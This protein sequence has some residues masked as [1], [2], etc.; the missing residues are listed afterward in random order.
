M[1]YDDD[2]DDVDQDDDDDNVDQDTPTLQQK[3]QLATSYLLL[4]D[5]STT[6]TWITSSKNLVDNMQVDCQK[7]LSW[8][9]GHHNH[10]RNSF[11]SKSELDC[12]KRDFIRL[13]QGSW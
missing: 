9:S 6:H 7:R 8:V 4:L 12:S 5:R 2:Y 1:I 13:H 10:P 3:H 11:I